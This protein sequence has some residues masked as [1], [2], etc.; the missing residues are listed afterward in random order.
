MNLGVAA[1]LMLAGC[2]DRDAD[3]G[4]CDRTPPLTYE[5]FGVGFM[6]KHCTACHSSLLR[7]EQR[8]DAPVGIDM[9]SYVEVMRFAERI[10]ARVVTPEVPTMPPGGGPTAEEIAQLNEWLA[11]KVYPDAAIWFAEEGE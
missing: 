6:D 3:T 7:E 8:N 4:L 10:E 1:L 11:C 5:G 9:D 2:G